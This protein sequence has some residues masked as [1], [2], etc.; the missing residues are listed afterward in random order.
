MRLCARSNLKT[1]HTT[2]PLD[3]YLCIVAWIFTAGN[4]ATILAQVGAYKHAWDMPIIDLKPS[5]FRRMVASCMLYGPSMFFAKASIFAMYIRVFGSVPWVRHTSYAALVLSGIGYCFAKG[6]DVDLERKT[7]EGMVIPGLV[8]G[9]CNLATD[10]IALAIPIPV[11]LGLYMVWKKKVGYC[12]IFL[13]GAMGIVF[14]NELGDWVGTGI[15]GVSC[16][17]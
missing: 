6:W 3:D 4:T 14:S 1:H 7:R 17:L 11:I 16:G 10:V 2:R 9:A 15:G 8:I 5:Y 13:T 12:A